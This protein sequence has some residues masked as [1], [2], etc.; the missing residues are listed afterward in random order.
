MGKSCLIRRF[1]LSEFP[2]SQNSTI[3]VDFIVKSVSLDG[4]TSKLQIVLSIQW[5]TAGQERFRTIITGYYRGADAVIFVFDKTKRETFEH[6]DEWVMEVSQYSTENSVKILVGNKSDIN[7]QISTEEAKAK[8]DAM[9]YPYFDASAKNDVNV[10]SIFYAVTRSLIVRNK[11][12]GIVP[13]KQ[14]VV[15]SQEPAKSKWCCYG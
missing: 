11:E 4:F 15:L 8:A 10:N 14:G 6:I 3:G 12:M 13:V 9:N 7:P 2:E 1:G 5:D